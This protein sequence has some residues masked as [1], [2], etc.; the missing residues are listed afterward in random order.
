MTD[1]TQEPVVQDDAP[2]IRKAPKAEF[3]TYF[4]VIFCATLP[5]AVFTWA[6]GVLRTGSFRRPSPI[7]QA[8]SQARII[9]PMIFHG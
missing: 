2:R 1:I 6:L 7:R 8:W 4:A 9:T 5:L 3:M